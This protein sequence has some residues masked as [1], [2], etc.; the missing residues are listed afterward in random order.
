MRLGLRVKDEVPP[1]IGTVNAVG[2]GIHRQVH[3]RMTERLI[4][5]VAADRFF[6]DDNFF[7]RLHMHSSIPSYPVGSA[8]RYTPWSHDT[9]D[10][11]MTVNPSVADVPELALDIRNLSKIY[12][13][14][15]RY[16]AKEALKNVSLQVPKGAMFALL[17][18]NG[19]GKS[20][21]INILGNLVLKTGGEAWIW[22]HEIG[23]DPGAAKSC[24]GI[25]PQELNM[26]AFFTPYELLELQAGL[27]G[28]PKAARKTQEILDAVGL[29]RQAHVYSRTLSGGMKRR[30]MVAKAIVHSPPVLIL[31]EPTAGVDV[32]LRQALWQ[33]VRMLNAAGTT[34]LLTTH[35]LEEA[36]ALC[37]TIAIIN[38][39][40]LVTCEPKT[41]LM[42]RLA[43]RSIKVTLDR[44]IRSGQPLPSA[45]FG[46][47]FVQ[48][49]PRTLLLNFRSD[50][51]AVGP[52]IIEVQSAGYG[53]ADIKTAE[54]R[55]EDIFLQ[56]T[57]APDRAA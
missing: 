9:K 57:R 2:G 8:L 36:E 18:P 37:D 5:P 13:A 11:P 54:T 41:A 43:A 53:I 46:L 31:D 49:G 26:D 45:P 21:L 25:V 20:T 34:I 27:F 38:H 30:L 3:H 44:D 50:Q 6:L 56:L 40:E 48:D 42:Q 39:G 19:A 17:G 22:G 35:Y 28:V 10:F 15:K 55:L 47:A 33:Y 14:S 24:I 1:A 51:P 23:K 16:P 52:A 32:E 4:A 7:R 12:R 29:T